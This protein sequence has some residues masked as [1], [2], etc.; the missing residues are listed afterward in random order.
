MEAEWSLQILLFLLLFNRNLQKPEQNWLDFLLET[1]Y[2]IV[3]K[4]NFEWLML[5]AKHVENVIF[6]VRGANNDENVFFFP[7]HA[8]LHLSL[9][10]RVWVRP[11]GRG[12]YYKTISPCLLAFSSHPTRD[13]QTEALRSSA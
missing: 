8:A 4:F 1:L 10:Q 7:V 12:T 11:D 6:L 2:S 13:R 5:P 9:G 3:N